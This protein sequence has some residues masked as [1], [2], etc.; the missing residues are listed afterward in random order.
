MQTD[1]NA[2]ILALHDTG[3]PT[4]QIEAILGL[5]HTTIARRLQHLTPRKTTE[6]YK[7]MRADILAEKQRQLLMQ[8]NRR[9]P[10]EQLS[11]ITAMGICY[12]KERLERG[13]STSNTAMLHADIAALQVVGDTQAL[14]GKA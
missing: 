13:M 9:T 7:Q 10:K 11:L 14:P 2:T 5:D 1:I 3:H 12:D 4:R 8:S 6:I